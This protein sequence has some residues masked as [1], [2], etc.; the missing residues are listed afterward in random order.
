MG[1]VNVTTTTIFLPMSKRFWFIGL[2][3]H[4]T[5][6]TFVGVCAYL[7][8][9]PD[10]SPYFP[11]Y[12]IP[13]H[14]V[15]IGLIAFFLDGALG[16]KSLF[17]QRLP[18]LRLAPVLVLALAGLEELAQALSPNRTCSLADF[19]A[20]TIGIFFFSWLALKVE[21]RRRARSS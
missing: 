8:V 19:A 21:Q 5:F 1:D 16:F 14:L 6:V 11:R 12:D 15:F 13:G 20:D 18:W 2:A 10:P 17:P 7:G 4:V 3:L 9:L